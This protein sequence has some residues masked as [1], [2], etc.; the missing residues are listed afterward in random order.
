M[1]QLPAW[2][3]I[4]PLP[5]LAG[6]TVA[7]EDDED[8]ED[9]DSLEALVEAGCDDIADESP[10]EQGHQPDTVEDQLGIT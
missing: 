3:L 4:D 9:D 1:A 7:D 6:L 10:S 2:R 8:D 5:I